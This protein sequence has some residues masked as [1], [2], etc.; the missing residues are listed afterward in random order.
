MSFGLLYTVL[1]RALFQLKM[2]DK[3]QILGLILLLTC[4]PPYGCFFPL[5]PWMMTR[6]EAN[7]TYF[8]NI[9]TVSVPGRAPKVQMQLGLW[10]YNQQGE[11]AP[12]R[13]SAKL[14]R[15]GCKECL[16]PLSFLW[17]RITSHAALNLPSRELKFTPGWPRNASSHLM[18]SFTP[19]SQGRVSDV[20]KIVFYIAKTISWVRRGAWHLPSLV[21]FDGFKLVP[22][23]KHLNSIVT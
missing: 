23:C 3:E 21:P 18:W 1:W 13:Y 10:L 12:G 6:L 15:P 4:F 22:I 14:D 16:A 2:K 9:V 8:E 20:K 19:S 5:N 17:G 7:F 11:S